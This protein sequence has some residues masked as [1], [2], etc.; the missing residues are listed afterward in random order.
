[1]ISWTNLHK[2][3]QT[4]TDLHGAV[5]SLNSKIGNVGATDLQT[6]IDRMVETD[7]YMTIGTHTVNLMRTPA[8]FMIRG[9][10]NNVHAL[11]Y[12]PRKDMAYVADSVGVTNV[13]A[14]ENA[15]T[16]TVETGNFGY[17]IMY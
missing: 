6:Q 12:V 3:A 16:F 15:L 7:M 2:L 1:M 5:T 11:I 9:S 17:S 10:G 4:C 14:N 13:S 8:I